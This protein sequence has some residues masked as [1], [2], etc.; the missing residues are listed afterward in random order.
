M[1]PERIHQTSDNYKRRATNDIVADMKRTGYTVVE[2]NSDKPWGA[3]IR[4]DNRDADRFI[5]EFFGETTEPY[6]SGDEAADL[7]PKILLVTPGQKLSWQMHS[8]RAER[9]RFLTPGAYH[10]SDTDEQGPLLRAEEGDEVQ[11]AAGERHRLVGDDSLYTIVAEVWQHIDG[12]HLSD[13]DD[14][15]RISDDYMRS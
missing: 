4:F 14:I 10:R 8:R 2:V 5:S 13:E 7:S 15:V 9:W 1:S 3:Y 12:E 11:I 6:L